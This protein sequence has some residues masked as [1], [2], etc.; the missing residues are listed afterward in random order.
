MKRNT[1]IL[2]AASLLI[3]LLAGYGVV[4]SRKGQ[5]DMKK[6]HIQIKVENEIIY[7]DEVSTEAPTLGKF[8]ESTSEFKVESE[9]SAYGF[10]I[11]G[12]GVDEIYRE[13]TSNSKYW[14]YYSEN[15]Q[16]CM[17]NNFCDAADALVIEDGDFFVF[18]LEDFNE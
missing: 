9:M 17:K 8:L 13:D 15:N 2:I 6:L 12:M 3:L 4:K 10:Y 14:V 18:T 1:K 5:E 16:Q 11:L 7:D